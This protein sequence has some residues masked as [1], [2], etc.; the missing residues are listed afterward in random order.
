MKADHPKA[1]QMI[2][3]LSPSGPSLRPQQVGEEAGRRENSG[4]T[5]AGRWWNGK[6]Q[7]LTGWVLKPHQF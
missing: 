7:S 5:V 2:W 4:I 6:A 3:Y 1:K